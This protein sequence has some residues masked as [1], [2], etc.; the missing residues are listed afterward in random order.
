VTID[1]C[2]AEVLA[3]GKTL[4]RNI[5]QL[6]R[7]PYNEFQSDLDAAFK[8]DFQSFLTVI[9]DA[10][11]NELPEDSPDRHD[12]LSAWN[13]IDD[14]LADVFASLEISIDQSRDM[15]RRHDADRAALASVTREREKVAD[16]GAESKL[17]L[18]QKL[19]ILQSLVNENTAKIVELRQ[20][21]A[22]LAARNAAIDADIRVEREQRHAFESGTLRGSERRLW[23]LVK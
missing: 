4:T 6:F 7:E 17:L 10:F 2:V 8:R 9:H 12:Y 11:G 23:S 22:D 21:V 16:E 19:M 20:R 13:R 15:R 1:R 5:T 3:L 14:F 18:T